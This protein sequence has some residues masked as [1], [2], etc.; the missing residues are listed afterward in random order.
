MGY[1]KEV[2]TTTWDHFG[3]FAFHMRFVMASASASERPTTVVCAAKLLSYH[4]DDNPE[5]RLL[6]VSPQASKFCGM[7]AACIL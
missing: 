1:E 6:L 5:R 3:I 7:I 4:T 2:S